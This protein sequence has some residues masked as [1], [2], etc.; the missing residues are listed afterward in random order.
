VSSR[1]DQEASGLLALQFAPFKGS[2]GQVKELRR[3]M[4]EGM[5]MG[6]VRGHA[7]VR[8]AVRRVV[9]RRKAGA[10]G[11]GVGGGDGVRGDG[12]E[13]VDLLNSDEQFI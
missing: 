12:A 9:E 4:K 1:I 2:P 13:V 3:G 7:E 10:Q 6:S 5:V 11:R 8:E